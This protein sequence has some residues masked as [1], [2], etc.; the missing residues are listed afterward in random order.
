MKKTIVVLLAL[1]LVLSLCAC[2]GQ[3]KTDHDTFV[4][5]DYVGNVDPASGAYAWVGMRTGVMESLFKFDE[6]LNVQKNLVEDYSVSD[7]GMTWTIV[8]KKGITFQSGNAF[9]AEAVK[10][11]LERT[12]SMQARADGELKIASM[13][14]DGLTLKITTREPNPTLPNCMCDPYSGI[15]DVKSLDADGN[16]TIGTGP[17]KLVE[18]VENERMELDAYDGYWQGKPASRHITIRSISDLDASSLAL[19]KGELDACYGLS[20]DARDLFDGVSG[21]KISQAATSR[22]YK[23]YF[24]HEHEFTGDPIFRKAVCMAVDRD[25]Y[26]TV[27]VNGAG[28]PTKS[29]FPA[30]TAF[31][32]DELAANTPDYDL[33]GAKALLAENGYADT[34][35]DGII[36]KDGKPVSLQIITYGRT[37][38]PQSS[39]ALA[40]ALKQL[41]IDATVEQL[42][43]TEERANA[44]TYDLS[45]YAEVTLPTGDPY[46]YIASNYKT[47]GIQNYGKYSD[48]E[49]DALIEE[50]AVEFDADRR[51][52]L[53]R[54]IDTLVLADNNVCNMYH[55]NMY[56]AMKDTVEGLVQSPVDYYHITYQT[57][58]K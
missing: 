35:G 58:V 9:D 28:T 14:A 36:E 3:Q 37:G 55:L 46:S 17:F 30:A 32:G 20:Y 1:M 12:C 16:A 23:I 21:F 29:T 31:G 54:Q 56:M 8:L 43:S 5:G 40:S 34:D 41:G 33:E 24:N 44:G 47:G 25:S 2:G 18:Y 22:V 13:E 39:Q 38:L 48:P 52:E 15:V 49:V 53:A 57:R 50:L 27:L 19:Q 51:A 4:F 45:V 10:A 6:K 26:A 42:E 11:S 7:D